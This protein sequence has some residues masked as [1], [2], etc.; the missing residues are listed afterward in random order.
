[1]QDVFVGLQVVVLGERVG[2]GP[3]LLR[4]VRPLRKENELVIAVREIATAAAV[5]LLTAAT[6]AGVVGHL[7]DIEVLNQPRHFRLVL[8]PV[9]GDVEEAGHLHGPA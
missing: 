2:L 8:L 4:Q 9:P 5:P 3:R 1:M 7:G 6:G